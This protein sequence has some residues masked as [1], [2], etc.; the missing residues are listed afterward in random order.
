MRFT[1]TLAATSMLCLACS[2][3]SIAAPTN[4]T[5][6]VIDKKAFYTPVRNAGLTKDLVADFKVDNT[7]DKNDSAELQKAIDKMFSKGGGIL[8]LPKG[9]YY[10]GNV[11]LKSNVHLEIA[12]KATLIP[13][14]PSPLPQTGKKKKTT[15]SSPSV[16]MF[17]VGDSSP[18]VENISLKGLGD[19]FNID[20]SKSGI[21]RVRVIQLLNTDNFYVGNFTVSEAE[22]TYSSITT[23]PTL[24]DGEFHSPKNGVI[25]NISVYG[26]H[27]GYGVT[28]IKGGT[29]ILF[30]NLHGDGGVALR[31][32]TGSNGELDNAFEGQMGN[33]FARNISCK[34]GNAAVMI[35]PHSRVIGEVDISGVT[36]LSCGFAVRAAAGYV[37]KKTAHI[38]GLKPGIFAPS[39]VRDIS[40]VYGMKAQLKPKHF[41]YLPCEERSKVTSVE[42]K[43]G[44]GKELFIGPSIA[45]VVDTA[46]GHQAGN[47]KL[48]IQNVEASGFEKQPKDILLAS[49]SI[50]TCQN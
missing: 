22:S 23:H 4:T 38:P 45:A 35:S 12:E 46:N 32:E 42:N 27:Y 16:I 25:E 26:A 47:Y 14:L 9:T 17:K 30:Q 36:D 21:N 18:T 2:T 44:N 13:P 20:I 34:N 33:L 7:D 19:G 11:S 10:L 28:Q 29:N 39:A 24:Y 49:D 3:S 48:D 37:A 6:T 8:H 1:F 50:K 5:E 31:L 40:A 43:S 15:K 41:I